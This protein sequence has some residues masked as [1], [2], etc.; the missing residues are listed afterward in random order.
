[1]NNGCVELYA[2][3]AARLRATRNHH[4]RNVAIDHANESGLAVRTFERGWDR[5]AFAA[6]SGLSIDS[7]RWSLNAAEKLRGCAS[8]MAPDPQESFESERRDLDPDVP[9]PT[10]DELIDGIAARPEVEWVEAGVTVE[11]LVG[12]G[13][14]VAARRRS[15]FWALI[16]N[17]GPR[18]VVQ[19]GTTRW[20]DLL[21]ATLRHPKPSES[22]QLSFL[23][24]AAAVLVRHY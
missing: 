13:G 17:A 5:A 6:S 20:T 16:G 18:L 14:W 22:S 21:D 3:A 19:R 11:V 2:K 4:E 9:L 15:R 1:M 7:L 10:A 12:C 23:P 24:G 8:A